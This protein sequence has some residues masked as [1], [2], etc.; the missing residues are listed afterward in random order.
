MDFYLDPIKTVFY[1]NYMNLQNV[2]N[3]V[4]L[5][6]HIVFIIIGF[7]VEDIISIS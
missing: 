1:I 4:C 3:N 7:F 5:I 2:F 6:T